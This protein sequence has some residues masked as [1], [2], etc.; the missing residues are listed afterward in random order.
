MKSP[1]TTAPLS[2][3]TSTA[4]FRLLELHPSTQ[5]SLIKCSLRSYSFDKS[6]PAYKALSYTWGS[7]Y[8]TRQLRL[9][10]YNFPVSRNLWIFL[11]QMCLQKQFGFYWI[12]AIC[13]DQNNTLEKNHQVQMMRRIYSTAKKV[14][15]WLGEASRDQT[16]D[17]AMDIVTS[18]HAMALNTTVGMHR[19]KWPLVWDE[20]TTCAV[21]QLLSRDYWTRIWIVQETMVAKD[22]SVYCGSKSFEW[23]ALRSVTDYVTFSLPKYLEDKINV[24]GTPAFILMATRN[25]THLSKEQ[26]SLS[27]L[28]CYYRVWKASNI[29]D[30]VYALCGIASDGD[31]ITIDYDISPEELV[32][33]L[34]NQVP[35]SSSGHERRDLEYWA[36]KALELDQKGVRFAAKAIVSTIFI[37]LVYSVVDYLL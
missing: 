36:R 4:Q 21:Y 23:Q 33:H 22:I 9:N 1:Y 11:E 37:F 25:L 24:G 19:Y 8:D 30:K 14:T 31:N 34:L 15:I 35:E 2:H 7:V 32:A 26:K 13:I 16:S 29:L 12:D 20:I 18:T 5:S 10:G 3:D 6:Y 17:M 27:E 28:L